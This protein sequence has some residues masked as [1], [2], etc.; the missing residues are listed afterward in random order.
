MSF[1]IGRKVGLMALLLRWV[2]PLIG[3]WH[4]QSQS[5]NVRRFVGVFLAHVTDDCASLRALRFARSRAHSR[6]WLALNPMQVV[7]ETTLF[8]IYFVRS[9]RWL[10]ILIPA[11]LFLDV[12]FQIQI[13]NLLQH[14]SWTFY[15]NQIQINSKF[16]FL[17]EHLLYALA[18]HFLSH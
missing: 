1:P 16:I 18:Y 12:T 5:S 17:A 8:T 2:L 13:S 10:I 9:R 7:I 6:A 15:L 4:C 3:W 14:L 11:V